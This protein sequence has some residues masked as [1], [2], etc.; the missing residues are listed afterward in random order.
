M[1]GRDVLSLDTG[2]AG[3]ISSSVTENVFAL[4]E[5]AVGNIAKHIHLDTGFDLQYTASATT[6]IDAPIATNIA[7]Y[8]NGPQRPRR[9]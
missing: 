6:A 4:R 7:P 2:S 3:Q 5:R 1:I 9:R 8:G